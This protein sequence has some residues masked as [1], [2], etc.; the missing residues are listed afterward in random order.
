MPIIS[1]KYM[2][3]SKIGGTHCQTARKPFGMNGK[4]GTSDGMRK[5]RQCTIARAIKGER[6]MMATPVRFT[7]RRRRNDL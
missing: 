2:V 6:A 7:S 5:K 1:T 4:N 3:L